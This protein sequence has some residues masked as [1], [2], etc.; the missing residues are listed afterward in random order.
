MVAQAFEAV[1]LSYTVSF[2]M[3]PQVV[4]SGILKTM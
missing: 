2:A 1:F 3:T 4:K